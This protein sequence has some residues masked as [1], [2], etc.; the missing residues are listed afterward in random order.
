MLLS[1]LDKARACFPLYLE[2]EEAARFEDVKYA[3]QFQPWREVTEMD[4]ELIERAHALCQTERDAAARERVE[5]QRW[6]IAY[7][8]HI[9]GSNNEPYDVGSQKLDVVL[10]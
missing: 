10:V 2:G 1:L 5:Q 8:Q 3:L 4:I 7:G 6:P 9:R